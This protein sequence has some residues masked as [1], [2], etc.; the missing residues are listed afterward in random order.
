MELSDLIICN[1]VV[2]ISSIDLCVEDSQGI[3]CRSIIAC[4]SL[5]S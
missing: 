3:L 1:M 5:I 4:A 2:A